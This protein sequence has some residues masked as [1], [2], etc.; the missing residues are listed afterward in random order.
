MMRRLVGTLALLILISASGPLLACMTGSAMTQQESACCRSM[1]GD[2]GAMAAMG[3]CRTELRTESHP[4]LA[5]P[6]PCAHVHL[7]V[8]T[9]LAPS[10]DLMHGVSSSSHQVPEEHAPPGLL[11]AKTTVLRI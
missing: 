9:R 2:C 6:S 7:A 4:Q 5:T 1:H 10:V 11:L 8:V 3:C